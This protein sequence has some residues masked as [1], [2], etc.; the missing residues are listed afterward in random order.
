[1]PCGAPVISSACI[2]PADRMILRT[3]GASS[4]EP[5]ER[6]ELAA[7][8]R[9]LNSATSNARTEGTIFRASVS[10]S[11]TEEGGRVPLSEGD[12]CMTVNNAISVPYVGKTD[13]GPL[14]E[15][16]STSYSDRT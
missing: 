6:S 15:T 10:Q 12:S 9:L 1:M 14:C 4:A 5:C 7:E 3:S 2:G 8:P 13:K 16:I 11:G